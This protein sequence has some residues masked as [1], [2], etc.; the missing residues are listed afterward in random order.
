MSK[1]HLLRTEPSVLEATIRMPPG[2]LAINDKFE[3]APIRRK[4][5]APR[6]EIRLKSSFRAAIHEAIIFVRQAVVSSGW[7]MRGS[8]AAWVMTHWP[9]DEEEGDVDATIK[10]ALDALE[11]GGVVSND[12]VIRPVWLDARYNSVQPG[13]RIRVYPNAGALLDAIVEERKQLL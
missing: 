10:A 13:I 3:V 5:K 9:G 8:A 12:K 1:Q 4:G 11:G 2:L 6:Y 7:Q